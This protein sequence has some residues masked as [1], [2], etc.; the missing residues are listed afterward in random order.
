MTI[1]AAA[2]RV[3]VAPSLLACDFSRLAFEVGRAEDAGAD[4]LH[5]DVMDG[6]FVPNLT[7]GPALVESLRPRTRMFFDVHLMLANP[8]AFLES[9]A[10][11]G[12]DGL[13]VH[14]EACPEPDAILDRIGAMG[15]VRG[16]SLN[17]DVPVQRLRGRL[18]RV[19]RLL[20]MTVFAGFG[21][22]KFVE[23][24][25]DRIRDARALLDAEAPDGAD[26]Q[27][28]GGVTAE[29]A[30]D[31]RAAGADNLVAGTSTFRAPDMAAAIRAIRG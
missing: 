14:V 13:T 22:Q 18:S 1:P 8:D 23:G 17:P 10:K 30:P 16:L 12:A 15:L 19:D 31:I 9:F 29:N 4:L 24:S 25:L 27:V 5:F 3:K 21:G 28:D 7:I 26:L 20:V 2:R 6:H 11:A